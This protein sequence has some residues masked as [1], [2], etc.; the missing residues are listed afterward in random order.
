MKVDHTKIGSLTDE[1][2][3]NVYTG[4]ADVGR[5]PEQVMKSRDSMDYSKVSD[6]D[7]ALTALQQALPQE[8]RSMVPAEE[9][10][11]GTPVIPRSGLY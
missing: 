6:A 2:T 5:S 4:R 11:D 1:N 8:L 10:R 9:D 3:G 7:A